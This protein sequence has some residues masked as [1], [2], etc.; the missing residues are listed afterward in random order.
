MMALDKTPQR[1]GDPSEH[2]EPKLLV[3]ISSVMTDEL[4]WV[5]EDVARTIQNLPLARPWAFEFTPASSQRATD[6]Y[7]RHVADAD[8]V[9]W[10]VGSHTTQPVVNEINTSIANGR[11]LLVFLLPAEGR[12]EVTRRLLCTVSKV[13]KWQEIA[14]RDQLPQALVASISDEVVRALRDPPLPRQQ[15]L[16]E[17]R[18][19]SVASCRQSWI[20]LGVPPDIATDLANDSSVGDILAAEDVGFQVV[21]AAAGAGKSLAASR[22]FQHAIDSAL[23]DGTKP[24]PLFV[25]ARDLNEPLEEYVDQRVAGLANPG[26]QPTLMVVDGLDEKGV[27]QA[28]DLIFQIQCYVE[29]YPKSRFL[30]TS[31]PLPG[32]QFPDHQIRMRPLTDEEI[33]ELVGRIAGTTLRPMD[34]Y[35]WTDSVRTAAGRPLFTV[36]IGAELRQRPTMRFDEP[37]DLVNRLAQQVVERSRQ[38]GERVHELLQKL[39][40]RAIKTGRR[41]RKTEVTLSHSEHRV[42][43][44]TGLLD[45][46]GTTIDFNH[47]VL[48]EWYAAQALVEENLSIDEVVPGSDRWMTAFKLVLDSE[49]RDVRNALRHQLASSDPGLASLLLKE[50]RQYQ[51]EGDPAYGATEPADRLGEDLWKAMDSWRQGLGE[52]FQAIGPVRPDGETAPVGIHKDATTVTTSWYQGTETLPH[53]VGL[54]EHSRRDYRYLDPGWAVLHTETTPL[55]GEWPWKA[56]RRHLVDGLSRT[57]MTRRLG[58]FSPHAVRELVWAFALAITNHSEFSGIRIGVR[59]VLESAQQIARHATKATIA[60]RIRRLEVTPDELRLIED[61]LKS[62]LDQDVDIVGDPW[63]S[64]DQRPSGGRRGGRTWDFYSHDRLVERAK[65]VYSAAL[66]LY[67]DM[68]DRWFGGFRSRLRFGRLFPVKLEGRLTTS[69]QAHW[70]GAPSLRW[71]AR[72][73]PEG[74]TSQVALEWCSGEDVDLLSYWKEEE[75]NLKL[76]RPGTDATPC[77]IRGEPLPSI[78]SVR[79]VT[80]L[81][82][83][84]LIGDLRELDWTDLSEV[85]LLR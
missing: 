11:R 38:Q 29:A 69:R 8:F 48:R 79:P 56:T 71:R 52:I 57:I 65:A 14:E 10:L 64:F 78:D 32:L 60:F 84:W 27:T 85:S 66:E 75:D 22:C 39:A 31:R 53:V 4:R 33:V 34:L 62:L 44:D 49:N 59:E 74:E 36:M 17:W 21:I 82:H 7:L 35:S 9:V 58:L 54:S 37:V 80:D 28:N 63:P 76:V 81:A 13:C 25:K 70:E 3:F 40:V 55:G 12:D 51:A 15:K 47:E 73:L 45:A 23:Q 72:A 77:P 43:A 68:V 2:S 6:S 19:L 30:A 16:E 24:F 18:R 1:R 5:R 83:A 41:V 50:T 61:G 26:H 42:L 46:S 67:E 20:A